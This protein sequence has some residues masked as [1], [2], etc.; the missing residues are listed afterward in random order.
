MDGRDNTC[1]TVCTLVVSVCGH[2]RKQGIV[3]DAAGNVAAKQVRSLRTGN[4]LKRKT[5]R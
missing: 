1:S 4:I 5:Y 2:C 3:V